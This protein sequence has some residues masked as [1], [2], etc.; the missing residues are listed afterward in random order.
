MSRIHETE[1]TNG[2]SVSISPWTDEDDS[3]KVLFSITHLHIKEEAYGS[4]PSGEAELVYSCPEGDVEEYIRT[5]QT[6]TIRIKDVRENMEKPGIIYEFNFFVTSRQYM[7]NILSLSFIVLPKSV[8]IEK[9]RNFYTAIES[10]TYPNIEAAIQVAGEIDKRCNT[11]IKDSVRIYRDN[12]T[13]YSMV[14]RLG[15]SWAS[16]T[17]NF[18]GCFFA[19]GWEGLL[20]KDIVG[21]NSFGKSEEDT[22]NLE[23]IVGDQEGWV[24]TSYNVLKYNKTHN[25]KLFNPW[26]DNNKDITDK[27]DDLYYSRSSTPSDTYKDQKPKNV[28]SSIKADWV[29]KIHHPDYY[30]MQRNYDL[31]KSF[32]DTGGYASIVLVGE[33]MPR[34][35]KLGDVVLYT[36]K[37]DDETQEEPKT[38]IVAANEIFFSQSGTTKNSPHGRSFEWTTVLWGIYKGEWTKENEDE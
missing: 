12:E 24:Q 35:W 14:K 10:E 5:R 13:S 31:N 36:R 27:N 9:G 29:Y 28:M 17:K 21:I 20:L 2:I 18:K 25:Y 8:D 16:G 15:M 4:I 23:K 33:E 37:M 26:D 11:N 19:L 6:G 7:N 34:Q 30:D 38:C 1:S 32:A 3:G 22:K